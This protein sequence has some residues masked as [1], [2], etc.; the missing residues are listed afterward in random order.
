M[1]YAVMLSADLGGIHHPRE[2]IEIPPE[3]AKLYRRALRPISDQLR[4]SKKRKEPWLKA[5]R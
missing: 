5:E 2:V 3:T 4:Q 1:K